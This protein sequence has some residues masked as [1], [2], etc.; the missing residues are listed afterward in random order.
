MWQP[1]PGWQ[2]LPGGRSAS[3]SGVWSAVVEGRDV[4]VK[5]IARPAPG[6]PAELSTPHDAAWWR[7]PLEVA[8]SGA[9]EGAPGLRSP[10]LLGCEEDDE[11]AVLVHE[12]VSADAAPSGVFVAAC[13]GRFGGAT[14]PPVAWLARD[15]LRGRLARVERR[16]GWRTLA[17]TAVADV[18]DHLWSRR[19][20][21]LDRLDALPQVPQHGDP[22]P[23]N[24]VAVDAEDP[25]R[26]LAVDW[27]TLGRGPVGADLGYWS[28]S[29][30]EAFEPLLEAYARSLPDGLAEP[31]DAA[32]AARVTA[33][34]TVLTRADW[35]LARVAEGEGP[36]AG[37]YRHPGVAPHL[38]ALQRQLPQIEALL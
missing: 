28:L 25:T 7:R 15:Q 17:R 29:A 32:Y 23:G 38:R 3:T 19:Q 36:L 9:V 34:L 16:G 26:C 22:V 2:P 10:R 4:V 1:E 35:A 24:L 14:L 11:G 13:L 20:A 33:A 30:R 8:L 6:D 27:A 31:V 12:R 18:A 5:R 21:M 37:K